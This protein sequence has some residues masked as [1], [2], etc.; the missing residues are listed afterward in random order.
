VEGTRTFFAHANAA[1]GEIRKFGEVMADGYSFT[2]SDDGK[3]LA[4]LG[5]TPAH[6]DEIWIYSRDGGPK[7]LANSNP[8]VTG[9]N[10]GK[11]QE[12]SWNS[13]RDG[14]KIYGVL[15]LPPGYM[16]GTPHKTIVHAHGG[17]FEAWQSGW[18]GTWY[19]WAQLLASH[20]Y[21]VLAP[22]P[23]GSEGQGIA[24]QE[25]NFEDWGGGD[26]QDVMDG[27]DLLVKQNIADPARLGIGGWSYGGFIT[28]WTITHTDRFKAAVVGAAV[29]DLYGMSTTTDI[30][31]SFLTE[32]FGN[33][34]GDRKLYDQHSPMRYIEH[35]HTPALVLHGDADLRVPAFQGEEFYQ[36]L[37]MLGQEAE[38]VRYPREPHIFREQGHQIDSLQRIVD[39][40]DSHLGR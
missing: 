8:Q 39:W 3:T 28:S 15:V 33:F 22:N 20:G 17:P 36:G 9:W 27:V 31:P 16:P 30:A 6:P 34:V 7:C 23:R 5:Q 26:F 2:L 19:E 12:I 18:L 25:A 13:S 11:V 21:V 24:F 14:Q 4:Y 32:F 1:S 40:F 37:R 10:L 35:C 38:L 29:T